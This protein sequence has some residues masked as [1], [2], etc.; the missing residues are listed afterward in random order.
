MQEIGFRFPWGRPQNILAIG[1]RVEIDAGGP[2][3]IRGVSGGDSF[4]SKSSVVLQFGVGDATVIDELRVY[5]GS[6]PVVIESGMAV[7]QWYVS[8]HIAHQGGKWA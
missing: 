8:R 2:T 7:N 4:W 6:R 1:S 3:C 5:G